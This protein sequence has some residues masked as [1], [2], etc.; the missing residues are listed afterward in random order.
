MPNVLL[1][2]S[3]M[4]RPV[5]STHAAGCVDCVRDGETGLL[6]PVADAGA[7]EAAMGRLAGDGALRVQLGASGRAHMLT[8][9]DPEALWT[10][11][12]QRYAEGLGPLR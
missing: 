1:E 5:V 7:L 10:R 12:A 9:F 3:A 8:S 6:V 11:L 4:G 2:G